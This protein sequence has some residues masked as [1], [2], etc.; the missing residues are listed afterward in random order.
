VLALG[1]ALVLG[2][3][4]PRPLDSMLYS[5]GAWVEGKP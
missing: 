2:L 5:A 1:L 3:W 4:L